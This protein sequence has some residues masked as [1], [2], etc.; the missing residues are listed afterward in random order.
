MTTWIPDTVVNGLYV[1][2][3]KASDSY[4]VKAKQRGRAVPVTVTLGKTSIVSLK[5]AREL[6]KEALF[7]LSQGIN[8]NEAR[9]AKLQEAE[10]RFAAEKARSLTLR[11]A[12]KIYL[13]LK[14][15]KQKTQQ[16]IQSTVDRR[17]HDWLEIPLKEISRDMVLHRFNKIMQDVKKRKDIIR[18]RRQSAGLPSH[19]FGSEDGRGEAQRA[20]RY[21]NAII[22]SVKNDVIAGRPLLDV[23]P[24]LVL[25]DKKVKKALDS[26]DRY[27]NFRERMIVWEELVTSGHE[28][29]DG[30]VSGDA[31]DFTLLLMATGIRLEEALGIKWA[32]V[33]FVGGVY[34]IVNTKNHKPLRLPLTKTTKILFE[35]RK[36]LAKDGAWVFPS[37]IDPTKPASGSRWLESVI[38]ET[39]VKFSHHDLRRTFATV[40]HELGIDT[41]GIANALN[42]KNKTV[43]SG[44][45]Q[46]TTDSLMR[47]FEAVEDAIF[48]YDDPPDN[49]N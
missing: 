1:R 14:P 27:L 28:Q 24:C 13:D 8:P 3:G 21:L 26:R 22:N 7:Q 10:S 35:R 4:A 37:P 19:C 2:K 31:A 49:L 33:D 12:T 18:A 47:I 5:K 11:Q 46:T 9:K 41:V 32:D 40:A 29:Y 42:H 39:G 6:A 16:D 34:T 15:R 36:K 20:F 25:V 44:Y 30:K 48:Y 23:N 17:F 43:T 38:A 45:I